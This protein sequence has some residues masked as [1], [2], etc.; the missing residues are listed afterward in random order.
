MRQ[1]CSIAA[2]RLGSSMPTA[3]NP[4]SRAR[5][6]SRAT[7]SEEV[8]ADAEELLHLA[9]SRPHCENDHGVADIRDQIAGRHPY[10]AIR[11][12]HGADDRAGGEVDV[13]DALAG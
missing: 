12:Q 2:F 3:S 9:H 10:R 13:A 6:G 11:A 8:H 5:I 7:T 1:S 4:I